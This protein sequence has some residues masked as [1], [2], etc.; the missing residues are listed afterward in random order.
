MPRVSLAI[1]SYNRRD[2]LG[3]AIDSVRA[4]TMPDWELVVWDDGSTD[5]SVAVAHAHDDPRIRVV[6]AEHSGA[7]ESL[8]QALAQ[9]TAPYL[10]WLD[11][12]D[13]L[14][15]AAL[16]KTMNVLDSEPAVGV[17]Y[18]DYIV[19]DEDGRPLGLGHRCQIPYSPQRMLVDFPMFHFRLIRRQV[20]DQVGGIDTSFHNA[21][22][23]DLCLRLSEVTAV[24]HLRQP[25]YY[26]RRH[27]ATMS[28]GRRM[29]Q[30]DEA[31]RAVEAALR[32][33]RLDAQYELQVQLVSRFILKPRA[34]S[35]SQ[36]LPETSFVT[37][38]GYN[39]FT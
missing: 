10:G 27:A 32:R 12:D 24:T 28:I 36:E 4:Q 13:L 22:D 17:V 21:Y 1:T 33:R 20:F 35:L 7:A 9:T 30:I 3:A 14:A 2:Y 26:Y 29:E 5:D 19:I 34:A 18:S 16:E 39:M 31:R 23:Y 15:P 25:L 8:R 38:N 37:K 6:A 11:S